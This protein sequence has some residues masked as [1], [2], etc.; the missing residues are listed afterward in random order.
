MSKTNKNSRKVLI[1]MPEEPEY[2]FTTADVVAELDV[3]GAKLEGIIELLKTQ[4]ELIAALGK[5]LDRQAHR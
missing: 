3:I 5:T 1:G 2:E 4:N